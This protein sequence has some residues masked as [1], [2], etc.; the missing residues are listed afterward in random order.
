MT[1]LQLRLGT[2]VI[3]NVIGLVSGVILLASICMSFGSA[4]SFQ[5]LKTD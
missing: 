4:K 3:G 5:I 2:G 1:R